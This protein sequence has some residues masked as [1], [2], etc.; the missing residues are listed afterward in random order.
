MRCSL[1][2]GGSGGGENSGD[3]L[4]ASRVP[5]DEQRGQLGVEHAL[6]ELVRELVGAG[7]GEDGAVV[8]CERDELVANLVLGLAAVDH[9][10]LPWWWWPRSRKSGGLPPLLGAMRQR[11]P[12]L[13]TSVNTPQCVA[14]H[15]RW[16]C[17]RL[18]R[19]IYRRTGPKTQAPS[20]LHPASTPH[21]TR[22]ST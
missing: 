4:L 11:Y 18:A 17:D 13:G 3:G 8:G 15:A 10:V 2:R 6:L 12:T 19:W 21:E 9:G 7:V 16:G 1:Y 20:R 5:V 14:R 22:R